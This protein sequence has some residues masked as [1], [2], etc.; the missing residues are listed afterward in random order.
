MLN[1]TLIQPQTCDISVEP[2]KSLAILAAVLDRAGYNARLIDLQIPEIFIKWESIL[3][4]KR[5]I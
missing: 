2:P 5:L 1:I 3:S 4:L